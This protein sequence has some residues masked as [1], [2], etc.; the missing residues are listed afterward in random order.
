MHTEVGSTTAATQV[1]V[2]SIGAME[3]SGSESEDSSDE[4]WDVETRMA[5][6]C[7]GRRSLGIAI[8]GYYDL[9][10]ELP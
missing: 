7:E 5:H 3:Q 8:A 4:L 6:F 10:P 1:G 2:G 9:I